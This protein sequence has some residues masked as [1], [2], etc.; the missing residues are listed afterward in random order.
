MHLFRTNWWILLAISLCLAA[1]MEAIRALGRIGRGAEARR[2]I[3][4]IRADQ[5]T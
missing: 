1:R 3:A 2:A 4:A 5:V